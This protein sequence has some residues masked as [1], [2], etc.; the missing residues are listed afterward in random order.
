MSLTNKLRLKIV[1]ELDDT[2]KSRA[3]LSGLMKLANE[4][5]GYVRLVDI[6]EEDVER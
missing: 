2:P 6:S 5:F 1:L 3:F 4:W